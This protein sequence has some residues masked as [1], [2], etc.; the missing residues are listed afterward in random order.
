[1]DIEFPVISAIARDAKAVVGIGM[2]GEGDD[3]TP[4]LQCIVDNVPA[5]EVDADGPL[6]AIV[7]NLDASDYL[8]RLAIGRVIRGTMRKGE[9]VA[10]LDEEVLEGTKPVE[11][12]LG[13]LMGFVGIGRDDV[14]ER[15][16]GDLFVVAGFPEVEIGDTLADP[17]TPEALPRLSV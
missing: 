5:P 10:L 14:D 12:K 16:A 3:L 2:P 8:G 1:A 13:N 11:R 6:Q 17:A 4:L 9:R 7:T 15:A